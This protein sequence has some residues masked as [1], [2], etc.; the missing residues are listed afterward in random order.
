MLRSIKALTGYRLEASDGEIG[1][2]K[3]FLF[4]DRDWAVRYMVADTGGWLS[5]R[6]VLISPMALLQPDWETGHFPVALTREQVEQSPPLDE[7]APVSREFEI[8]YH[9]FYSLPFYWTGGELWGAYPDPAGVVH[10]V[11]NPPRPEPGEPLLKEGH[12]R[13]A[14][15]VSGYAVRARDGDSEQLHDLVVDDSSWAIRFLVVNTRRW[16]PGGH[17]LIPAHGISSVNWTE[18][19]LESN[20]TE[21]EIRNSPPF[22]PAIPI[23]VEYERRLYDYYGRPRS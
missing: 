23:N 7:H 16:L 1:R 12:L 11:P 2:C 14:E 13:S 5:G 22:D 21:G 18:R 9:R 4:D 8:N 3:D 15:E 19:R 17:V 20:L 10:P 6:K